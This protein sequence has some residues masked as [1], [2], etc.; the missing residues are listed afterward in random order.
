MIMI[1]PKSGEKNN[2]KPARE[3]NIEKLKKSRDIGTNRF[4][5]TGRYSI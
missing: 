5:P 4:K 2:I 3:I 1:K